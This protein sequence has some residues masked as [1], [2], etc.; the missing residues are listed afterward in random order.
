MEEGPTTSSPIANPSRPRALPDISPINT[1]VGDGDYDRMQ[2]MVQ[3]DIERS[4]AKNST[5]T[6]DLEDRE[7]NELLHSIDSA[8]DLNKQEVGLLESRHQEKR[9]IVIQRM[10][11]R[12][13]L[14]LQNF[15]FT[16]CF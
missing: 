10:E 16:L 8:L 6:G 12:T 9:K 3:R 2:V 11:V 14:F 5:A 4:A 13:I 1:E 7:M 15:F